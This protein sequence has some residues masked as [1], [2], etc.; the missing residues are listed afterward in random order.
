MKNVFLRPLFVFLLVTAVSMSCS[1]DSDD[2][3]PKVTAP[4]GK[5]VAK[6]GGVSFE[7]IGGAQ[8]YNNQIIVG[9]NVGNESL[10]LFIT[11]A[12]QVGTYDVK[13]A[14]LGTTPDAEV[15]Y[16]PDGA[17]LYSSVYMIAGEKVGAITI[18][19]ID[20]TNKTITGTFSSKVVSDDATSMEITEGSF[21]K[22]P[23]ITAPEST[24][25]AKIDGETFT[26]TT[27]VGQTSMGMIVLNG[28]ALNGSRIITLSFG[29]DIAT[30]TYPLEELGGDIYAT[31]T[32]NMES[33]V[34]SSGTLTITKHDKSLKRV[35]GSF[36]FAAS[37]FFE[38]S[39][40]V[41]I[42]EGTFAVTYR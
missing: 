1:D 21:N 8:L 25:S 5:I 2:A 27:A 42:T 41:N 32:V 20:E 34:S 7:G 13:G 30:G 17:S 33:F 35:E 6:M 28:Q 26:A 12:A 40:E 29:D 39:G 10:S 36:S 38:E 14:Q 23:Y 31:Y 22:L 11:K 37:D 19:E 4:E 24:L 9:G 18:I 15:N 16:S 3:S